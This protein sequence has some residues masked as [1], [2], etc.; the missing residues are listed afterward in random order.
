MIPLPDLQRAFSVHVSATSRCLGDL[1]FLEACGLLADYG[2][3][4]IELWFDEESD[5]LKPSVVAADPEAFV[6]RY[7]AASR[8]TPVAFCF[9][10]AV[11]PPTF[12]EIARL[13]K[14]MRV[15]QITIPSAP[16]GTPFNA[17]IE[18]LQD[19]LAITSVDGIQLS[20][21]TRIGHLTEDAHTAVELCQAVKGLGLSLDPSCYIC[22]PHKDVAYDQVYPYVYHVF[23]RDTTP[24][25][26]QVQVGLGEVDYS[27]LISQLRRENYDRLL[28]VD[29]FPELFNDLDRRLEL[30]T[31]R[32]LL[33][34]LLM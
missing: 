25:A 33:E 11:E 16:L 22:G 12:L 32:M 24:E 3:T 28:S 14:L 6:T 21:R 8:L 15:A 10:Q 20:I 19:L 9:E 4:R 13:A 26:I 30:R 31:L 7:R 5:H 23:L 27:R 2:Y 34:S 17:E 18:R 29:F 1:D